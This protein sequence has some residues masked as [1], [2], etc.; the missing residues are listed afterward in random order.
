MASDCGA[1][2]IATFRLCHALRAKLLLLRFGNVAAGSRG[3]TICC[4]SKRTVMPC[5]RVRMHVGWD[6][7]RCRGTS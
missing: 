7:L 6:W 2:N 3:H 5:S 1:V 4:S